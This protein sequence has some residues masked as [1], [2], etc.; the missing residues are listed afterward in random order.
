MTEERFFQ[1]IETYGSDPARWPA[2]ERDAARAFAAA[3]PDKA[4]PALRMEARLDALLGLAETGT[5]V[6]ELLERRI[7]RSLPGPVVAQPRWQVPAAVAAMLLV[8]VCLGF[9]SGAMT[10]TDTVS[11]TVYADA[12]NGLDEDWVDWLGEDA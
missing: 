6:P 4:V 7:L 8:G 9:A 10:V 12:F 5:D 3:H 11:D 1:I 2:A